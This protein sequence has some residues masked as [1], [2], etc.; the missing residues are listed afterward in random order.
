VAHIVESLYVFDGIKEPSAHTHLLG[1]Y[2]LTI[3][4][5]LRTY[6]GTVVFAHTV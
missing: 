3:A 4:N 6:S 5:Q 2:N 1:S